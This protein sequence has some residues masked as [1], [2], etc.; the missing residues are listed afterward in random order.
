MKT[1]AMVTLPDGKHE[2][3]KTVKDLRYAVAL[4]Y[5]T[6]YCNQPWHVYRWL[7]NYELAQNWVKVIDD[8]VKSNFWR[9]DEY[10]TAI[11]PVFNGNT[12]LEAMDMMEGK[13]EPVQ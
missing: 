6:M 2:S 1:I 5:K 7:K 12:Y 11:L 10:E 4:R 13:H 3:R 9:M 8:R